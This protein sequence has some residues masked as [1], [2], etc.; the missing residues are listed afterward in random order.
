MPCAHH[1]FGQRKAALKED[2][3]ILQ[4]KQGRK[5]AEFQRS[6]NRGLP[7]AVTRLNPEKCPH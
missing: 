4:E 2:K 7:A 5:Q 1:D 3:A 6:N